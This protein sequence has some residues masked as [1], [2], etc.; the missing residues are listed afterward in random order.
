M[1]L[2][3]RLEKTVDDI[4]RIDEAIDLLNDVEDCGD[5]IDILNDRMKVLGI[6]RENIHAEIEA[7]DN[8]EKDALTREY[9]RAVV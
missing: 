9:W 1:S 4:N 6:Q 5:V 8:R 7:Q 3:E 2:H